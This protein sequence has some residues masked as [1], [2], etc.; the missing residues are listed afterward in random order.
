MNREKQ[1]RIEVEKRLKQNV[2]RFE[3]VDLTTMTHPVWMTRCYQNGHYIVMINDNCETTKGTAIKAMVQ[4]V[5]NMPLVNHWSEM[6]K[7]KNE[8][9]GPETVAI[10]YYPAQSELTDMANIYWMFIYP[11]DVL[12]LPLQ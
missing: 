12:P 11:S 1:R 5:N 6:Q 3:K 4:K 10:E 2:G 7:I 8:I 9:F